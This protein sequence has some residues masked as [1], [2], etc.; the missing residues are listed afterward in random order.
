MRGR[1]AG[2][3]GSRRPSSG[4]RRSRARSRRSRSAGRRSRPSSNPWVQQARGD[5]PELHATGAAVR[6]PASSCTIPSPSSAASEGSAEQGVAR[7]APSGGRPRRWRR[8]S[9]ATR[10]RARTRRA[11][12]SIISTS[13]GESAASLVRAAVGDREVVRADQDAVRRRA[14]RGSRR[15]SR[16]PRRLDHHEADG[17]L[18]AGRRVET[19]LRHA[20]AERAPAAEPERRVARGARGLQ[21]RSPRCS[22]SAR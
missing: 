18:V 10:P 4:N 19:G 2:C 3:S 11:I 13:R 7:P 9:P 16:R 20:R 15:G 8:R 12:R 6:E 21:A 5:D 22:P 14:R 17:P 1:R